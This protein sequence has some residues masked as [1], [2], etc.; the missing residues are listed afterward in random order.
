MERRLRCIDGG[1]GEAGIP[2]DG[3]TVE[4]VTYIN[5]LE[6]GYIGAAWIFMFEEIRKSSYVRNRDP[7]GSKLYLC[8]FMEGRPAEK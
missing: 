3:R 8:H 4:T 2:G 6:K 5:H 7:D 1:D